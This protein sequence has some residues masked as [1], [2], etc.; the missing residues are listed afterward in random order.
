[1]VPVPGTVNETRRLGKPC[2]GKASHLSLG[3]ITRSQSNSVLIGKAD[4]ILD[5]IGA[6]SRRVCHLGEHRCTDIDR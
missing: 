6:D 2:H 3:P 1:M 4:S 5:Q